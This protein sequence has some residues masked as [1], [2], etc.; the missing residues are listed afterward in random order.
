MAIPRKDSDLRAFAG[1]LVGQCDT[2]K[3]A[4]GL[5]AEE[6]TA[7][8]AKQTAFNT[9]LTAAESPDRRRSDVAAKN[10]AKKT[11]VE[12][13]ALF[14]GKNLDYN[15]AITDPI[16]ESL[17]LPRRDRTWT[18]IPRPDVSPVFYIKIKGPRIL[19]V[20]YKN[21][22]ST[23]KARPKGYNGAV[24]RYGV[25][26]ADKTVT[27]DDLNQSLLATKTPFTFEFTEAERGK[28]VYFALAWENNRGEMGPF[29][30][31]QSEVIP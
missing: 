14:I 22:G 23:G 7:L 3:T 15:A 26:D 13:L 8:A 17:G 5:P 30:E 25:F 21:A 2:N 1:N 24:I 27:F 16:R 29:S 9:A 28:K 11:L 20:H 10:E 18:P 31:L 6:I 12:A 19:A 4:W